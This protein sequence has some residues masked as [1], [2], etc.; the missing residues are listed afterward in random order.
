MEYCSEG[1]LKNFIKNFKNKNTRKSFSKKTDL[2]ILS[3][4]E[5]RYVVQE[6]I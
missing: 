5:A 3:E 2:N 4:D 6:I 1:D